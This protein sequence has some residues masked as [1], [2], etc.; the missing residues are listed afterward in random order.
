[1]DKPQK[2]ETMQ[3][4]HSSHNSSRKSLVH[5]ENPLQDKT[6]EG[7]FSLWKRQT[8]RNNH[9]NIH[10]RAVDA[11]AKRTTTTIILKFLGVEHVAV[12]GVRPTEQSSPL[13]PAGQCRAPEQQAHFALC[14]GEKTATCTQHHS[15]SVSS[16]QFF[17][18][19][20]GSLIS[21]LKTEA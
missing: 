8:K 6:M 20:I 4:F 11:V 21:R 15:T 19:C 18:V 12:A 1:M 17:S 13:V 9:A 2:E 10:G 16:V 5:R 3:S 7:Y 14:A